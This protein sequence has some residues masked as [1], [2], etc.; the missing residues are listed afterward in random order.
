MH[1]AFRREWRLSFDAFGRVGL[2]SHDGVSP[3]ASLV[4]TR[5]L[6]ASVYLTCFSTLTCFV[7][8]W[9]LGARVHCPRTPLVSGRRFA[10]RLFYPQA[11]FFHLRLSSARVLW[12]LVRSS[13]SAADTPARSVPA[14]C[15]GDER[16]TRG[17]CLQAARALA[18]HPARASAKTLRRAPGLNLRKHNNI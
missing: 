18:H 4:I 16:D 13:V 8:R 7:S 15:D 2:L 3:R 9:R 12:P 5:P 1:A 10:L 17:K 6:S 11:A 14:P